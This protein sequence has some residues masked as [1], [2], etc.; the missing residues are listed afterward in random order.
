[1]ANLTERDILVY[2]YMYKIMYIF[3]AVRHTVNVLRRV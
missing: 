3:Q 2:I 1:M